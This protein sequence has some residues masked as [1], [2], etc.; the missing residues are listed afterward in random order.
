MTPAGP[1]FTAAAHRSAA[2]AWRLSDSA[3]QRRFAPVLDTWAANAQ[4]RADGAP[5]QKDLFE[6]PQPFGFQHPRPQPVLDGQ[7]A[8]VLASSE[9]PE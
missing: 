4:L 3:A 2:A 7:A 1:A 6:S 5:E 9:R 8:R